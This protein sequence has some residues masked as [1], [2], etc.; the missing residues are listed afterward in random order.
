MECGRRSFD[1]GRKAEEEYRMSGERGGV[2][3]DER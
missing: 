3:R 1:P 2:N